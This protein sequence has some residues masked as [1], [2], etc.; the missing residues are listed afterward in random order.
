MRVSQGLRI[1]NRT[2]TG[3]EPLPHFPNRAQW[4]LSLTTVPASS[5]DD[6]SRSDIKII[7]FT[8]NPETKSRALPTNLQD[9]RTE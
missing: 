6:W 2:S 9:G 5:Y 3:R 8:P 7:V 4:R 1:G